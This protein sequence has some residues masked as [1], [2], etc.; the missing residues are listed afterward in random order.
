[1]EYL[2]CFSHEGAFTA[3]VEEEGEEEDD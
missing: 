2:E 3:I 1:V